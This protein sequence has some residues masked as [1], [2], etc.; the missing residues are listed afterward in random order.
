M[1]GM[2][3]NGLLSRPALPWARAGL[4]SALA[5]GAYLLWLVTSILGGTLVGAPVYDGLQKGVSAICLAV[6]A[7]AELVEPRRLPGLPLLLG[8]L[9]LV[10]AVRLGSGQLALLYPLA[11]AVGLRD[12]PF[13]RVA[14]LTVAATLVTCLAV[15]ACSQLGVVRDYVWD[16]GTRARH[17]LGFLYCTYPSHYLFNVTTLAVLLL[18]GRLGPAWALALL[19]ANLAVYALTDSKAPF[20]LAVLLVAGA[21][22]VRRGGPGR[23]RAACSLAMGLFVALPCAILALAVLYDPASGWMAALNDLLSNRLQQS[24]ATMFRY[25]VAPFGQELDLVGKGLDASGALAPVAG[26][27]TN[28]VDSS[29][30]YLLVHYGPVALVAAVACFLAVCRQAARTQDGFLGVALC[31]LALHSLLDPQLLMLQYSTL[32]LLAA[33]TAFLAR[34]LA[35]AP[36]G[37]GA[38]RRRPWPG[39]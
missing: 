37:P 34:G 36:E 14:R 39:P 15:A 13:E 35:A 26:R 4:R 17:G 20:V 12:E 22:A 23:A 24:H 32:V 3:Q 19:A 8:L 21:L 1:K 29:Y 16:A 5:C 11:F 30:L 27:D 33:N 38:E 7:L 6:L 18:R 2:P 31:A 9:A 10:A 25:G 28:Y